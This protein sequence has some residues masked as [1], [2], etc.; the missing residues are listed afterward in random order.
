MSGSGW[1]VMASLWIGCSIPRGNTT[2][3]SATL[4]MPGE[5][6]GQAATLSRGYIE[7]ASER[8][9]ARPI[10]RMTRMRILEETA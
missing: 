9:D 1:C 2:V 3:T 7:R 4:T 8:A 6:Y 10:V 5:G